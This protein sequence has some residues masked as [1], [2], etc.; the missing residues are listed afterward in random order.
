[1]MCPMRLLDAHQITAPLAHETKSVS[2]MNEAEQTEY[3]R[4]RRDEEAFWEKNDEILADED[5][6]ED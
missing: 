4:M 1:M 5:D 3:W 2:E 6:K